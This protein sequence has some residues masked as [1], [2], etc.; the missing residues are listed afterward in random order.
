MG[1]VRELEAV[2]ER[3]VPAGEALRL[4]PVVEPVALERR[5]KQIADLGIVDAKLDDAVTA[6][7]E[8]N[9]SLAIT[10]VTD[11]LLKLAA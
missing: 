9:F 5:A 8:G 2:D 6:I 1:C 7:G 11:A 10:Y 4:G 3:L